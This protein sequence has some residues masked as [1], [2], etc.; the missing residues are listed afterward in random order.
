[1]GAAGVLSLI[2]SAVVVG[3][4]IV[5]ARTLALPGASASTVVMIDPARVVD[6]R[7]DVGLDG[8]VVAGQAHQFLVTG[9]VDPYLDATSETVVKVVVPVG[10]TG[11][12]L[13]VTAVLPTAPGFLAIR[14]GTATGVP[15]TAGLNFE[16][17]AVI[18]NG[19]TVGLP[20]TGVNA[21]H[22]DLYYGT[23]TAGAVMHVIVD[24][25]GY[26]T[27]SGLIDLANRVSA[28]E[29]AGAA[30]AQGTPGTPGAAGDPG[31]AG[32][33][34]PVE[35]SACVAGGAAGT[36]ATS[37]HAVEG[38]CS[39]HCDR[40]GGEVSTFAG[41]GIFGYADGNGTAASFT[42]PSG[43]AVDGTGNVYVADTGNQKI[44]MITSTGD[45][46]T[47][48]GSGIY[49]G[50]NGNGTAASFRSPSGVAV[51]GTGNVYVADTNNHLIRKIAPNG[52]VT[53]FAGR[54]SS[55]YADGNGTAAIFHTPYGVAVDGAGNVY[56]ADAN[57]QLIRKIT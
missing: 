10:A 4:V 32:S 54:G 24:V 29:S 43:V 40:P 48:A 45:V 28:L 18:A 46:T 31:V 36:I 1:M 23:P 44:R 57:N 52:D 5:P 16:S 6:T 9:P 3:S 51:D 37:F 49:G 35:G 34:G 26:T 55:G 50:A 14:T 8:R 47:L 22:I 25:V 30:G 41:S 53:T 56:V 21:G 38:L 27:S 11:V 39:V 12:L 19:I 13:N 33:N 7:V 15:A 42:G 17:G 2:A 20:A